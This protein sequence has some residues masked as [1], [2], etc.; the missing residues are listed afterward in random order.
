MH[1]SFQPGPM[2]KWRIA[3]FSKFDLIINVS[4]NKLYILYK[5]RSV[6]IKDKQVYMQL[7]PTVIV[8]TT[9]ESASHPGFHYF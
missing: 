5:L 9:G 2:L 1:I 3:S 6:S 4:S 7:I 8:G